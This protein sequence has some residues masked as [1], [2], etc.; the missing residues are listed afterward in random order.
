M[1][2]GQGELER[3]DGSVRT[4]WLGRGVQV[5][6]GVNERGRGMWQCPPFYCLLSFESG[7]RRQPKPHLEGKLHAGWGLMPFLAP[8]AQPESADEGG[9]EAG[10]IGVDGHMGQ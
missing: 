3:G 2:A 4:V 9:T 7:R 10:G 5:S 6:L 1:K 8:E